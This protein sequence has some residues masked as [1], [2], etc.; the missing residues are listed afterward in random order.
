MFPFRKKKP[1]KVM[2]NKISK[3]QY[4]NALKMTETNIIKK[5]NNDNIK[6]YMIKKEIFDTSENYILN[7]INELAFNNPP[8][9]YDYNNIQDLIDYVYC[10]YYEKKINHY[11]PDLN[12]KKILFLIAAHT[13]SEIK[14]N[15]VKELINYLSFDCI[16]IMVLN[17]ELLTYSNDLKDFCKEKNIFYFERENYITC[18]SGKWVE[19]LSH[20]NYSLYDYVFFANDSFTIEDSINHFINLSIKKNVE[21][22]AYND[23]T[24][25]K[26]HYQSY[27]FCLKSD[28]VYKYIDMFNLHKDNIKCFQDLITNYELNMIDYFSS[29][30]CFLKIGNISCN[31]G[32]NIFFAN[33]YLYQ[34]LKCIGV[35]P[36]VKLKRIL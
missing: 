7:I 29:H 11:N 6:N 1:E 16:E 19:L 21:L 10:K 12:N 30:D 9:N 35:L 28:V 20:K 23:S 34:I 8:N 18:D 3:S 33:D 4:M 15:N 22:Y 13:N 31:T 25:L 2:V 5:H 27:L 17:T 14:L 24:E 32:V 26:Y 36:F